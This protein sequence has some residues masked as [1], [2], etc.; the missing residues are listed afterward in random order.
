MIEL[1]WANSTTEW[2]TSASFPPPAPS[3][4]GLDFELPYYLGELIILLT[5]IFLTMMK[6]CLT[7]KP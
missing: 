3:P 6:M 2:V 4:Q 1:D 5:E 7:I